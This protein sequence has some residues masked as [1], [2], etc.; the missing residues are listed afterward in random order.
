M[1]EVKL[2]KIIA[3]IELQHRALPDSRKPVKDEDSVN[4][5]FADLT[6]LAD[7]FADRFPEEIKLFADAL[8]KGL[9]E[10]NSPEL[11]IKEKNEK[12]TGII[13]LVER[14]SIAITYLNSLNRI[15]IAKKYDLTLLEELNRSYN[16]PAY[17][18]SDLTAA[19]RYLEKLAESYVQGNNSDTIQY[20]LKTGN[21]DFLESS[22]F[23]EEVKTAIKLTERERLKKKMQ[24][25]DDVGEFDLPEP[26]IKAAIIQ[27]ER[28][29]LKAVM[30]KIDTEDENKV[31]HLGAESDLPPS[32]KLQGSA[33]IIPLE[34]SKFNWIRYAVAAGVIGLITIA[35]VIV[36]TIRKPST[37]IAGNETNVSDTS[38]IRK[39]VQKENDVLTSNKFDSAEMVLK[40]RKEGTLG[41]AV[42]EEKIRVRIYS[43]KEN[44]LRSAEPDRRTDSLR[45]NVQHIRF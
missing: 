8:S 29:R 44:M 7:I 41:F 5:S 25:L 31:K 27:S 33:S 39:S 36:Y 22:G 37:D 19:G 3:S 43:F 2:N 32:D 14:N 10:F 40:V 18:D 38:N 9:K 20:L 34:K 35:T 24:F 26:E 13:E 4:L 11:S 28:E 1:L 30:Q 16:F 42:T 12:E 6:L 17:Q 45:K 15:W 23:I 21:P